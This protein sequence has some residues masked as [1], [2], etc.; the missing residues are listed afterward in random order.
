MNSQPYLFQQIRGLKVPP[1]PSVHSYSGPPMPPGIYPRAPPPPPS[2]S[3][4]APLVGGPPRPYPS[5]SLTQVLSGPPPTKSTTAIPNRTSA[6]QFPAAPSRAPQSQA[7]GAR[8]SIPSMISAGATPYSMSPPPPPPGYY[9]A[10]PPPPPLGY[11][12]DI[13][14]PPPVAK[15]N[16][17]GIE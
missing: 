11:Y 4:R 1:P 17:G 3:P 13:P 16:E 7:M 12:G 10:P 15:N 8:I 6:V 9:G 14:P 5:S 2:A